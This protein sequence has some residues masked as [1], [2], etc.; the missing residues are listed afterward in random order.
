MTPGPLVE[1]VARALG[2]PGNQHELRDWA[3]VLERVPDDV[4]DQALLAHRTGSPHP[5][6]PADVRRGATAI[7]NE[8]ALK[9]EQARLRHERETGTTLDGQPLLAM[10]DQVRDGLAEV[11][12]RITE[13]SAAIRPDDEPAPRDRPCCEHCEHCGHGHRWDCESCT[14]TPSAAEPQETRA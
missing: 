7:L 3:A 8:R 10:P 1:L 11:N 13:R 2:R 5:P 9:A 4:A 6:T 12:R 14:R